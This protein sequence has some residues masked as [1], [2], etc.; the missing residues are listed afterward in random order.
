MIELIET[1]NL[2]LI[3]FWWIVLPVCGVLGYL[4]FSLLDP[5][6][7]NQNINNKFADSGMTWDEYGNPIIGDDKNEVTK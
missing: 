1:S 5:K 3:N 4:L 7:K 6:F 2:I